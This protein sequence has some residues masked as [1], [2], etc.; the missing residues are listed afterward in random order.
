MISSQNNIFRTSIT[1][2]EIA[3]LPIEEFSGTIEV[4]ET[5]EEAKKALDI[6]KTQPILGFDSETKP[7]FTKGKSNNV[8]LIQLST[9][10]TCY[11][12][13]INKDEMLP[14]II[15]EIMKNEKITKIGLSLKD[16]FTGI[17]KLQ[18]FKPNNCIDLQK[19][20]KQFGITDNS[21]SKISISNGV[22]F[23]KYGAFGGDNHTITE[24]TLPDSVT[25]LSCYAFNY[26]VVINMNNHLECINDAPIG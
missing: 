14:E 17:N 5:K 8:C 13:R 10:S 1:K 24:V 6:L 16:D 20:V 21:L 15:E 18:K 11:L 4:I 23:I 12:F 2:E 26:N 22:E 9:L 19:Y 7:S 3:M 25:N